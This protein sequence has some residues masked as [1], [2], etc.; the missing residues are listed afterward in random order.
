[1]ATLIAGSRLTTEH[2]LRLYSALSVGRGTLAFGW[3]LP[4]AAVALVAAMVSARSRPIAGAAVGG[5]AWLV[6]VAVTT[7]VSSDP[8][9][10]LWGAWAEIAYAGAVVVLAYLLARSWARGPVFATNVGVD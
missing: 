2:R 1:V 8:A 10:A 6:L 5:G 3:L 9:G 7:W 4:M